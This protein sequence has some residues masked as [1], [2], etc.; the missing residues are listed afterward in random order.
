MDDFLNT[1]FTGVDFGQEVDYS[2]FESSGIWYVSVAFFFNK[3]QIEK[4]MGGFDQS[5]LVF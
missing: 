2:Q 3:K 4:M 1:S 5:A